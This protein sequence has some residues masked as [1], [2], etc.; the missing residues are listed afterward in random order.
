MPEYPAVQCRRTVQQYRMLADHLSEDVPDLW[1]LALDHLL[2]S[3]DRAGETAQLELAEDERLEKLQC[4]LSWADHTGAVS[5]WAG[6][7]HGTTRVIHALTQQ[8]LTEAALLAFNHIGQ[9]LQRALVGAGNR[10]TPSAVIQQGI[11]RFLQHTLFVADNNVW[12]IE[13]EQ[14]LKAVVSVDHPAIQIVEVRR[15]KAPTIK[16]APADADPAATPAVR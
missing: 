13:V 15:R 8:I 9:R 7:D 11:D 3:F 14:P 2:G 10:T 16:W 5:V 4:H 6:H 12:R 1:R